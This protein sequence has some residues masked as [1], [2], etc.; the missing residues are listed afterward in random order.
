M[1]GLT[2]GLTDPSPA[3]SPNVSSNS[4][5]AADANRPCSIYRY[6]HNHERHEELAIS[7]SAAPEA[8]CPWTVEPATADD[9][10]S[11]AR[12]PDA[13]AGCLAHSDA[14]MHRYMNVVQAHEFLAFALESSSSQT[15][16]PPQP[17][18]LNP[19]EPTKEPPSTRWTLHAS[20]VDALEDGED[21]DVTEES[22][23]L[24]QYVSQSPIHKTCVLTRA[25]LQPTTTERKVSETESKSQG[26]SQEQE[27]VRRLAST[28]AQGQDAQMELSRGYVV[29]GWERCW[30]HGSCVF[31]GFTTPRTSWF[32]SF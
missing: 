20:S 24:R 19:P 16:P 4:S 23:R 8:G 27:E 32:V 13:R 21:I 1:L 22:L 17:R 30:I 6:A 2:Y 5:W 3:A 11:F 25:L 12:A 9:R 18:H 29:M 15:Q 26:A 10:H 14:P 7:L 31:F 28:R